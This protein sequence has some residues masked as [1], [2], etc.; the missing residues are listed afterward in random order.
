MAVDVSAI[1]VNKALV[2]RAIGYNH[3][4]ADSGTEI[5]AAD[6]VAHMPS[7]APMNRATFEH[8]V[9]GVTTY[10]VSMIEQ[11]VARR[12]IERCEQARGGTICRVSSIGLG[13]V[14]AA[15]SATSDAAR[16]HP[17]GEAMRA[18]L[19]ATRLAERC[20]LTDARRSDVYYTALLRYAG[21]TATSHEYAG[22]LGGDDIAVRSSG[23]L[24][25]ATQPEEV[26]R[27]LAGLGMGLER[28]RALIGE[29]SGRAFFAEA[30]RADCE[31]G[32]MVVQRAG[33]PRRVEL[34]V[35]DGFERYDGHGTPEGKAG[36][37]VAEAARFSAVAYTTVMFSA[38]G[39]TRSGADAVRQWSGRALDPTI[40][41]ALLDDAETLLSSVVE[42]DDLWEAVVDAEPHPRRTLDDDG[43]DD[44]LRGFAAVADLKSPWFS[45]HSYGVAELARAAT[46]NLMGDGP[47]RLAYRAG[48]VHDLG[49]VAVPT[50]IW[51]RPG[52]LRT[53]ERELVR[54]HPY[55]SGR[56]LAAAPGLA[57]L[58]IPVSRH[59][60]RTD[61]SGYPA[62]VGATELDT[63]SCV[64]GAA[65]VLHAL[66]EARP[67]RPA[68]TPA[69][70][71][72]VLASLPLERDAIRAVLAACGAPAPALPRLPASITERELEI[73]RLLV[74]GQTERQIAAGLVISPSTV[75]T[76]TTHVYAKCGVSTRAGLAMFAMANGLLGKI[77]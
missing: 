20:R 60:E 21:C 62:G 44:L 29:P 58:V 39:G 16:G 4:A 54:L 32:A 43:F 13:G 61:G 56:I 24:I 76:H 30:A 3:R 72:D 41:A 19:L 75:H 34:A 49:R 46:R 69:A 55:R 15:L 71:A 37:A 18:C 67:Y 52:P 31:V 9:N 51:E 11:K 47:A 40:A 68:Y 38:F 5:F 23:D 63:V 1:D 35:L 14:L 65:D 22:A 42:Q 10:F 17:A 77:D 73:V 45:G 33:L 27:F 57:P 66:R 26:V 6:F 74:A 2:R 70:A 28:A 50:G 53:D 12:L 59:H 64:L 7:Q 48:L 8:F 25:D 36:D